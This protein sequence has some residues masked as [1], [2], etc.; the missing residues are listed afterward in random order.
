MKS[1]LLLLTFVAPLFAAPIVFICCGHSNMENFY[2]RNGE[3][4]FISTLSQQYPGQTFKTIRM[5]FA[6]TTIKEMVNG[7][8]NS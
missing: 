7:V 6:S 8:I 4:I 5:A 2:A 3:K 1:L